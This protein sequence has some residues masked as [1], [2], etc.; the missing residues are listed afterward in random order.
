MKNILVPTDLKTSSQHVLNYAADLALET[1]SAMTLLH[2]FQIPNTVSEIPVTSLSLQYAEQQ[3]A[4]ELEQIAGRLKLR[5]GNKVDIEIV[6]RLGDVVEC[7]D[8]YC[9]EK[10]AWAVV[11]GSESMGALERFVLGGKTIEAVR[12][13]NK[14]IIVV[15]KNQ[16]F[17]PFKKMGFAC[18]LREVNDSLHLE[19]LALFFANFQPELHILHVNPDATGMK[20]EETLTE[21][22]TL[23]KML[24]AYKPHFHFLSGA[25]IEKAIGDYIT[26]HNID[27]LLLVPKKN[28]LL[29]RL[30]GRTHIN[31]WLT[32]ATVPVLTIKA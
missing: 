32:N 8:I 2:C 26:R 14:P 22:M 24:Q 23:S 21:S 17:A 3:V 6:E 27:L 28:H 10:G 9:R 15:G 12:Y 20:S 5:T 11:M 7:I 31:H 16:V 19:E 4:T 1:G 30:F 25:N 29:S 13:V 18:D